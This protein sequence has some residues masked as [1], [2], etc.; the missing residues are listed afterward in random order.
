MSTLRDGLVKICVNSHQNALIDGKSLLVEGQMLKSGKAKPNTIIRVSKKEDI[1]E[2]FGAGSVIAVSLDTAFCQA[3]GYTQIYALPRLDDPSGIKPVFEL[4]IY[5]DAKDTIASSGIIGIYH[6]NAKYSIKI[7]VM[8]GEKMTVVMQRIQK[9][10]TK[11]FMFDV[12][13]IK[14]DSGEEPVY[15]LRYTS[16]N[17]GTVNNFLSFSEERP[18]TEPVPSGLSYAFNQVTVGQNDPSFNDYVNAFGQCCHYA[19]AL[20]S[21]NIEWQRNLINFLESK[22][23]CTRSVCGGHGYLYNQGSLGEI[24]ATFSNSFVVSKMAISKKDHVAPY[25][26]NVA[27]AALSV[28]KASLNTNIA[29]Q[30]S[31]NGVL[32]C[33]KVPESCTSDWEEEEIINLKENAFVVA[34]LGKAGYSGYDS[35]YVFNDVTNYLTNDLGEKDLTYRATATVRLIQEVIERLGSILRHYIGVGLFSSGTVIPAGRQ[36]LTPNLIKADL[37]R[38]A[39]ENVG[40]LFAQNI[41]SSDFDV[42]TDFEVAPPCMGVSGPIHVSFVFRPPEFISNFVVN[43]SPRILDNCDRR[44]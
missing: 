32:S 20:S 21:P 39:N 12:E 35:P 18:F 30:G 25:I 23:D 7:P 26:K 41:E 9:A 3:P 13:I 6:A 22:W 19:I 10:Y 44:Q 27:Y 43:I 17:A 37:I 5:S 4:K 31:D 40:I 2:L 42:K 1:N 16:K 14:S 28:Y 11:D 33:I 38:W 15:G 29:I 8:A 24:L 36:G 34:E